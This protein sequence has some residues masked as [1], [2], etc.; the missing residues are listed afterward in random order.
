MRAVVSDVSIGRANCSKGARLIHVFLL[1]PARKRYVFCRKPCHM[2]CS[3]HI[4]HKRDLF[5]SK[6][7]EKYSSVIQESDEPQTACSKEC[8][9]KLPESIV[10][11]H[12]V[13]CESDTLP[14]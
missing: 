5:S 13:E 12:S 1:L 14:C 11:R 9:N 2:H 8:F 7:V 6:A 4:T 10:I 3:Y